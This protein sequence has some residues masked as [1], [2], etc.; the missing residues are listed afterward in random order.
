M[1]VIDE[2]NRA[3]VSK[4]FGELIT[5][6]EPD[7]RAGEANAI[8]V[9]LPYSGDQFTL[10]SNLHVLGTMN[11]ADR[12]IALL[13]T[14]L[15]RRFEFEEVVPDPRLLSPD[16]VGLVGD[17]DLEWLLTRLNER[18]EYLFD[19]DHLI[20]HAFFMG[21][22]TRADVDCVMRR[23]VIPLLAEYFHEDWE[24]IVAVLGGHEVQGFIKRTALPVPPGL[25]GGGEARW[26]YAVSDIFAE[27]A[28]AGLQP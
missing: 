10:P 20:G 24:K 25:D 8:T 1:L 19:R 6:L 2:I 28:Y 12:S 26:R 7:K 5:L 22:T 17:L 16:R 9:R 11:T 3:N 4:V 27:D 15:R 13:D 23:K 18:V 14:A 21:S